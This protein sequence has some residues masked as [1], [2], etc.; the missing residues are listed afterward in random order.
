[1]LSS[2]IF[3]TALLLVKF[4]V[5]HL[6]YHDGVE[7]FTSFRLVGNHQDVLIEKEIEIVKNKNSIAATLSETAVR[8]GKARPK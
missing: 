8:E 4:V 5:A 3:I 1:M 2:A 6:L 7:L